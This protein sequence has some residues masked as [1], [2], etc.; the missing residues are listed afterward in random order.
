METRPAISSFSLRFCS[1]EF[2]QAKERL[3]GSKFDNKDF[4]RDLISVG[5]KHHVGSASLW[6]ILTVSPQDANVY[7]HRVALFLSARSYRIR[8][9]VIYAERPFEG[10]HDVL[11]VDEDPS[12]RVNVLADETVTVE[13]FVRLNYSAFWAVHFQIPRWR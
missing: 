2:L 10:V 7:R 1:A 11:R 13:I 6:K 5:R 4:S 9:F 8:D 3:A 12:A